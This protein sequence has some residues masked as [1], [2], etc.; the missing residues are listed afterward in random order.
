MDV[1]LRIQVGAAQG[2]LHPAQFADVSFVALVEHHGRTL[3]VLLGVIEGVVGAFEQLL[4]GL[5]AGRERAKADGAADLGGHAWQ[6]I[7][8]AQQLAQVPTQGLQRRRG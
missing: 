8:R 1:H 4:A 6:T 3:E 2:L 7:R 5:A